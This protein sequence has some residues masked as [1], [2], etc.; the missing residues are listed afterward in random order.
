MVAIDISDFDREGVTLTPAD[1]PDFD[2]GAQAILSGYASPVLHLKPYLAIVSNRD[3]RTVVAYAV[4]W[5]ATF[6]NGSSEV[7]Y[8]QLQFPDAVAGTGNGLSLLQGREIKTGGRRLVGM[9]FEVWPV[10]YLDSYRDF[11][12][13]RA[14]PWGEVINLLVALDAVI[15]EDGV[16]LGP[17]ESRLA[18]HFIE[19]VQAKQLLYRDIVVGFGNGGG[20][21]EVFAPLRAIL[22]P[23]RQ[24]TDPPSMYRRKAAAE[25]L[26]F[27]DRLVLEAFGRALRREAFVIQR[28]PDGRHARSR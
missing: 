21:E 16:L 11:G 1:D 12:E 4:A 26:G 13:Q 20:M 28:Q 8:T 24:P 3:P 5:T 15:F 27:H 25:I 22:S 7:T 9:G 14:A 2:A 6:R 23:R 17:D 18:E 10:E 19:F